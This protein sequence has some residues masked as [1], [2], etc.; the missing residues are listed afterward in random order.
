M[1]LRDSANRG[2]TLISGQI[3]ESKSASSVSPLRKGG[4]GGIAL[5]AAGRQNHM[6][7]PT[8]KEHKGR[9]EHGVVRQSRAQ[10]PFEGSPCFK[11]PHRAVRDH[12]IVA[13]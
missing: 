9:Q 3:H 5:L 11:K 7:R 12:K 13:Q 1:T 2:W 8:S 4:S 10:T 6:R